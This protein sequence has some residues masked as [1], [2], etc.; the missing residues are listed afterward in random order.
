MDPSRQKEKLTVLKRL[1]D[2]FSDMPEVGTSK[3]QRLRRQRISFDVVQISNPSRTK[4]VGP[5]C[6][7]RD[8]GE[9]AEAVGPVSSERVFGGTTTDSLSTGGGGVHGGRSTWCQTPPFQ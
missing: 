6:A 1:N 9:P 8:T 3:M 2:D 4:P 5:N 7:P